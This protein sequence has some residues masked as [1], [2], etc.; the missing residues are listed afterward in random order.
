VGVIDEINLPAKT[1][2]IGQLTA[3]G[4]V[5]GNVPIWNG[6]KF[7]PT[8]LP[9]PTPGTDIA[10]VDTPGIA[11]RMLFGPNQ[12]QWFQEIFD[13]IQYGA[14]PTGFNDSSGPV[15]AAISDLVENGGGCLYVP[16]GKYTLGASPDNIPVP[17]LILGEGAGVSAM[18]FLSEGFSGGSNG[19]WFGAQGLSLLT[20]GTSSAAVSL[21][22]GTSSYLT[23]GTAIPLSDGT[24]AGQL[25]CFEDLQ[26]AGFSTGI[27]ISAPSRQGFISRC[28]ILPKAVGINL[29]CL[30]AQVSD[31]IFIN[32]GSSASIAAIMGGDYH[33]MHGLRIFGGL[34]NW[35]SG[36]EVVSGSGIA[37]ADMVIYG[38]NGAAI[39]LTGCHSARVQNI[40]F[41]GV[42]G[43]FPVVFTPSIHYVNEL[44]GMGGNTNTAYDNRKEL[45]ASTTWNP[46]TINASSTKTVDVSISGV[47]PGD[48]ALVGTP[49]DAPYLQVSAR[50]VLAN[51]VRITITNEDVNPVTLSS[52]TYRVRVFN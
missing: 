18:T 4:F 5:A 52:G 17:C 27:Y 20:D 49:D 21:T 13:I 30:G 10:I 36:I 11:T 51:T 41:G 48:Q 3:S 7:T 14:D 47:N 45:I 6:T 1:P 33:S 35:A 42:L 16:P 44:H 25:F 19:S 26:V 31:C 12:N 29:S 39:D 2:D 40:S 23:D 24:N 50:V 34:S 37:L 8:N 22:D 28:R 38:C 46:G 43:L 15:N 9:A 32:A